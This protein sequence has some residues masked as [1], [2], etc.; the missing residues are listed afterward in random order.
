MSDVYTFVLNKKAS[1]TGGD[2]YVWD[3]KPTYKIYFDQ[4]ISRKDSKEPKQCLKIMVL[5]D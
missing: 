4:A 1:S 5:P 3:Q 2:C